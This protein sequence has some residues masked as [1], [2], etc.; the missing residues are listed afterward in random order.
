[1]DVSDPVYTLDGQP[2]EES[3]LPKGLDRIANRL[4]M[5]GPGEYGYS[6]SEPCRFDYDPDEPEY[7]F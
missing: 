1:M 6:E 5:A 7:L 2:I 3:D 4:Y